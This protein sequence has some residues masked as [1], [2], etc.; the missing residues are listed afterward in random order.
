MKGEPH[1]CTGKGT[2]QRKPRESAGLERAE[3]EE[4]GGSEGGHSRGGWC[5]AAEVM[6]G[7]TGLEL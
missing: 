3:P 7:G 6:V 4:C 2:Q 5:R 1:G